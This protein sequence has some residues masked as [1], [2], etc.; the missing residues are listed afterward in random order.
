MADVQRVLVGCPTNALKEYCLQEYVEVLKKLSHRPL[1]ALLV[2]NSPDMRYMQKL[3]D[4]GI[5]TIKGPSEGSAMERIVASR[6]LLREKAI[7]MK[8]DWLLMLEQDVIP[9]ADVI[10]KLLEHK[11]SV[12]TAVY[13]SRHPKVGKDLIPMV[14]KPV[15]TDRDGFPDMRVLNHDEIFMGPRLQQVISAGLGCVLIHRSVFE[16][17]P[18]RTES[19]DSFDDYWFFSDLY[20]LGIPAFVDSKLRCKHLIQ[21]KPFLWGFE[22]K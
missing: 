11:K 13:F 21:N 8:Y 22:K 7:E 1:D 6:N 15:P 10:E 19:D 18:F 12:V 5:P 4:L 17:I 9:P 16:K 2:D 20:K 14:F 3:L